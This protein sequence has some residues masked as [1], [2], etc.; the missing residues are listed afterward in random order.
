MKHSNCILRVFSKD[1]VDLGVVAMTEKPTYEDL[2]QRIQEL[3]Q[4]QFKNNRT[5]EVLRESEEHFRSLVEGI[6]VGLYRTDTDGRII[7]ANPALAD[8]LG[9][10]DRESLLKLVG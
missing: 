4:A 2:L 6:P 10:P 8:T 1:V 5:I 7:E 3:E 9:F